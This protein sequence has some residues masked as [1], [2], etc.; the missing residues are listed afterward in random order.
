M[1]SQGTK[2]YIPQR[3]HRFFPGSFVSNRTSAHFRIVSGAKLSQSDMRRPTGGRQIDSYL[4]VI[5]PE[6]SKD[7]CFILI[8]FL[9][10]MPI[11]FPHSHL[12][13]FPLR[14]LRS[15]IIRSC[16]Q[17]HNRPFPIFSYLNIFLLHFAHLIVII[18]SKG[19]L[20]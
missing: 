8:H 10:A 9:S 12:T 7:C 6:H 20:K 3:S 13:S 16:Q 5:A 4:F 19:Y 18:F 11:T 1:S 17:C 15:S 2:Q 14:R